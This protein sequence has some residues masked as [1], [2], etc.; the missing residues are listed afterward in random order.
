MCFS[1]FSN[2]L[3]FAFLVAACGGR[4]EPRIPASNEAPPGL[5]KSPK[6]L[7]PGL[8]GRYHA[9]HVCDAV[10]ASCG[11]PTLIDAGTI[12]IELLPDGH[13]R[14]AVNGESG[15]EGIVEIVDAMPNDLSLLSD[16]NSW[17]GHF[18]IERVDETGV[19]A[20]I[21]DQCE[22]AHWQKTP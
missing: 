11:N 21:N 8:A 19:W 15:L 7:R 16:R 4:P 22:A 5:G 20:K 2:L 1:R 13:F 3:A 6:A 18:T 17:V 9:E 12:D 10:Y 14:R